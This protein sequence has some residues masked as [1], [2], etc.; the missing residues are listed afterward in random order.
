MFYSTVFAL[1]YFVLEGFPS[2]CPIGQ[3]SGEYF[4]LRV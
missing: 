4:V 2:I 1:F 3:F